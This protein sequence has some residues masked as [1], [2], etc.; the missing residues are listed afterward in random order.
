MID[1]SKKYW[2]GD[3]PEDIGQYLRLYAE[4]PGLEVKPVVCHGCGGD[5]FE[6]RCDANE[7][8]I[9]V[10]CAACGAKRVLLDGEDY[11]EDAR[12]RLRRCRVCKESKTFQVR[13]G[14]LRREN[15]DVRW[16]YIGERCT[17]C[18]TLGSFLDWKVDYSPTGEM[19]KNL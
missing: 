16:V 10:K 8:V 17:A 13:A 12:P 9:Q 1:R 6:V 11:W 4:E 14:F 15:G 5:A 7:G 2:T 3:S 18:G 19:E